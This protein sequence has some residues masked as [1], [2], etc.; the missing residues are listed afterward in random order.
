VD[1]IIATAGAASQAYAAPSAQ[2]RTCQAFG[3]GIYKRVHY[4][5]MHLRSCRI[6]CYITAESRYQLDRIAIE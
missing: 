1:L 4:A 3:R 5:P 6:S 2:A